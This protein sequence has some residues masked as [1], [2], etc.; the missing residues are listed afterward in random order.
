MSNSVLILAFTDLSKD[1]RVRR[2][3][4]ALKDR[5]QLTVVGTHSPNLEN[6]DFIPCYMSSKSKLQKLAS[7][8]KL[9]SRQYEKIYWQTNPIKKLYETF[10]NKGFDIIIANDIETLPLAVKIANINNKT[11]IVLDAHEYAPKEFEDILYWRLLY[12]PYKIYLC[13]KYF[14]HVDQAMTVC[15]GIAKEYDEKLGLKCEVITNASSYMDNQDIRKTDGKHIKMVFHGAATPSRKLDNLIEIVKL[16]DERFHLDLYLIGSEEYIHHLRK[17][18]GSNPK[19]RICDPVPFDTIH[20]ML[21]N[22]DIGLYL[23]EPNSFNNKMALPN[24]LF[25]FVQ[26]RLAIAIGP[27]PEMQHYVEKYKCGIVAKSFSPKDL[28]SQLLGLDANTIDQ[29]KQNASIMAQEECA[30]NNAAKLV[31][32]MENLIRKEG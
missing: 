16:L 21:R 31:A 20:Q 14:K 28:A 30:Q 24:K 7:L 13:K 8:I 12:K 1:P 17:L 10:E 11:K 3:I 6:I 4:I 25:E 5:Y 19:I 27:S 29:F 2:Q 26:A 9:I 15:K 23:L 32:I 18:S 22:Y